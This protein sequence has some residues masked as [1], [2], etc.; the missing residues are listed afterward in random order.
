MKIG[1]IAFDD[2]KMHL[3][4]E[5][6]E[7]EHCR[8]NEHPHLPDTLFDI[9][10]AIRN[11]RCDNEEA[12]SFEAEAQD[13]EI[14]HLFEHLV[15]ELQ[16]QVIGG[17]LS[18]ETSWDWTRDPHGWFHVSVDY[19]NREL[20]LGAVWLAMRIIRAIDERHPDAIDMDHEIARLRGVALAPQGRR[21]MALA[22]ASVATSG[23]V[24]P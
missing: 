15:I 18:G 10:P 23:A 20:A 16:V 19:D 11:H 13:T 8:T 7:A 5:M 24:A 2:R 22:K 17:S 21:S 14:P 1:D 12:L 9:L 3:R 4:I 6:S